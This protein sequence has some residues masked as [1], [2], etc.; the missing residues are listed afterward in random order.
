MQPFDVL[1]H[2]GLGG[3]SDRMPLPGA[4]SG[5]RSPAGPD[6]TPRPRPPL[7]AR[8]RAS[9][10]PRPSMA[11]TTTVRPGQRW[12][13]CDKRAKGRTLTIVK[14]SVRFA[15]CIDSR[16]RE[17]RIML[18]RFRPTSTGYRLVQEAPDGA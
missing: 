14:V 10:A 15:W 4:H 3:D 12:A 13:D 9:E 11:E 1:L 7:T 5:L 6:A 2:F 18:T 16:G 17:T 8:Q